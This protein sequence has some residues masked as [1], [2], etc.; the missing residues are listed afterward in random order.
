[1]STFLHG[2]VFVSLAGEETKPVFGDRPKLHAASNNPL[3]ASR[4]A[5]L[6]LNLTFIR[7]PSSFDFFIARE[8]SLVQGRFRSGAADVLLLPFDPKSFS[9]SLQISFICFSDS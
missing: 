6:R 1:M 3:N 8:P 2:P 7:P 9:R 4:T 5:N